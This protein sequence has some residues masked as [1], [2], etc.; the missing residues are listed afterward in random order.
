LYRIVLNYSCSSDTA[1]LD[2][3]ANA[4]AITVAIPLHSLKGSNIYIVVSIAV[5]V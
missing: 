5:T 1:N 4:A 2:I 3:V